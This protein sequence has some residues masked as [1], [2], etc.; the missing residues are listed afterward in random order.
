MKIIDIHTH[1]I[2]GFD[3]KTSNGEDILR[4]AEMHG[5]R[6]VSGILVSIYPSTIKV[7]RD[8]ME[9]VKKAMEFQVTECK[10][11]GA[12]II[13]IHLEG[14]FLNPLKC[15][16]MDAALFLEPNYY[17]FKE[18]IEGFEDIV[19]IVTV[20][21]ELNGSVGL[22]KKISDMGIIV[23]MGHSDA[24]YNE[25]EAGFNAGA[26]GIT[27]IFNAMRG[28]HHREPGIAG[29]GIMNQ[30]IYIEVIA[31]PYHLHL[32]ALELLFKAKSLDRVIIISDTV[33]ETKI[34]HEGRAIENSGGKLLGGCMTVV[35]SS[36]RLIKVGFNKDAIMKCITENPAGYLSNIKKQGGF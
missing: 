1:G 7:M 26:R 35:E 24:T 34:S 36:E 17:N 3:S 16:A 33:R 19:E 15:G 20:A 31:D 22:I 21:P 32:K 9:A 10:V 25:A 12:K 28:F 4:I 6:G 11:Q 29:F 5:S 27:H 30:D 2:G 14:P 18:L 23:S 13:G 8:N